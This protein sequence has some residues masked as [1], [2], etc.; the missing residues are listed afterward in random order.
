[1]IDTAQM[2]NRIQAEIDNHLAIV[3]ALQ[4]KLALVGQVESLAN[5]LDLK[6]SDHSQKL[7]PDAKPEAP[8]SVSPPTEESVVN[9]NKM[10]WKLMHHAFQTYQAG[11]PDKALELFREV[12]EQNPDGFEKNWTTMTALPT[13]SSVARDKY[14]TENLFSS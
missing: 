5:E 13:Y 10:L 4:E 14:F 12:R 9:P 6:S 7:V 11:M 3:V 8:S 1:M 2:R